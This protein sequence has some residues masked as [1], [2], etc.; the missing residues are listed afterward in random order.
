M[1]KRA[2]ALFDE[3]RE[4]I[5]KNDHQQMR[6]IIGNKD[7]EIDRVGGN[8]ER[9]GL[10]TATMEQCCSLPLHF[11]LIICFHLYL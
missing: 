6:E 2:E 8:D 1:K 3:M 5:N 10:H 9:T 11:D 7:Y 4:A